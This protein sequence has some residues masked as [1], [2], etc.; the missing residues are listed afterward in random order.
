MSST[1]V[2]A[3]PEREFLLRTGMINPNVFAG[4]QPDDC[5]TWQPVL[6]GGYVN[7]SLCNHTC[8]TEVDGESTGGGYTCESSFIFA[9][10]AKGFAPREAIVGWTKNAAAAQYVARDMFFV[11]HYDKYVEEFQVPPAWAAAIKSQLTHPDMKVECNRFGGSPEMLRDCPGIIS[12]SKAAGLIVNLTT[13][14]RRFMIDRQ[15]AE[16]IAADPP[17]ILA[18]SFDDVHPDEIKRLSGMSLDELKAGWREIPK[19]HGQRQ[20]AY[21][22][23]YASQ[24]LREMKVPVKHL[25]NVVTHKGNIDHLQDILDTLQECVPGCL[26]N[27][28]PA[29]SFGTDPLC[30]TPESLP[31]LRK[32]ILHFITGTL[33]G[34]PGI[35]RRI[36]YYN[37]L[38][39][40]FRKWWPDNPTRLCQFMSGVGAW[41]FTLRPG[42][43]RYVQIARNKDIYNLPQDELSYPGGHIGCFWNPHLSLSRQ[44]GEHIE[45]LADTFVVGM[46]KRGEEVRRGRRE[47][48]QTSSIMP[49]LALDTLS[50]E[51]GIPAELVPEYLGTRLE[52][53]GF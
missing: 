25:F 37:M 51:L 38:E 53:C 26:V 31:A 32:H 43:Y 48:V 22:A 23:L 27:A 15:F 20:K 42:G 1:N 52:Y 4:L 41:D 2:S 19:L 11:D 24:L 18:M 5:V 21:E 17:Q 40:A 34:K 46:V 45:E 33:E 39:A 35:N 13:P 50:L 9:K 3:G 30:W 14:G 29:Q 47:Y 49:R 7:H 36:S 28:F 16:D 44:V 8:V 6:G 10:G 12:D